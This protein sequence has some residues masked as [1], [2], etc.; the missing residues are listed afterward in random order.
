MCYLGFMYGAGKGVEQDHDAEFDWY[1]KAAELGSD[2]AM[3][4]LGLMYALG[5]G[6]EMDESTANEW[7]KKA[8]DAGNEIAAVFLR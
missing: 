7:Y 5:K 1:T 2:E 4:R 6:V 3:L 8:A